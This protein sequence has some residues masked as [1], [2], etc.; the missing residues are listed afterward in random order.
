MTTPPTNSWEER[1]DKEFPPESYRE[2][3]ELRSNLLAFIASERK[4]AYERGR[5]EVKTEAIRTVH[6][7]FRTKFGL[8]STL[9]E[10]ALVDALEAA[11]ETQP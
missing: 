7:Y 3:I 8:E 1:F 6:E 2:D 10:I 4:E 9:T 11:L 5:K